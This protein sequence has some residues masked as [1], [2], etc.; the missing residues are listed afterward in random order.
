MFENLNITSGKVNKNLYTQ[1]LWNQA[2]GR[3]QHYLFFERCLL[4]TRDGSKFYQENIDIIIDKPYCR[5]K[6]AENGYW[7]IKNLCDLKVVNG[8][9]KKE[10]G[11]VHRYEEQDKVLSAFYD[12]TKEIGIDLEGEINYI[13]EAKKL[14]SKAKEAL[15]ND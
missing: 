8:W 14:F 10:K 2:L 15:C 9:L 3:L 6:I 13:R 7:C 11:N 12:Y 4:E 5:K 1:G